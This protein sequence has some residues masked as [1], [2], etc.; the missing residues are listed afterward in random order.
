[1]NA[2]ASLEGFCRDAKGVDVGEGAD[3]G[4]SGLL[5]A[6]GAVLLR[7]NVCSVARWLRR[8]ASSCDLRP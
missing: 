5:D 1:M 6:G 3:V 8:Q 7:T 4:P 2:A